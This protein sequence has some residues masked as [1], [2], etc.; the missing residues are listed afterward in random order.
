VNI[1]FIRFYEE[2]NDF[3][4]FSKQKILYSIYFR[5]NPSIKAIIE[6]E[7][8]PHTE[9]DLVLINGHSVTFQ[10]K[11]NDNDHISVY[12]KFELFDISSI[13]VIRLK[14]L[15]ETK[16]VL[17]VHLG[18]LTRYLRMLG[19]D[20]I[21]DNGFTD[22]ELLRVS[23]Q[24]NRTLLTRNRKLLMRKTVERG[25]WIR[26]DK[27]FDQVFEVFQRFDLTNTIK[28]FSI[29][30]ICNGNLHVVE[31]EIVRKQFPEFK[32]YPN[33]FFY[34]CDQCNHTYWNGSHCERFEKSMIEKILNRL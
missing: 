11:V 1:A 33:T 29:C 12:P 22:V 17:D 8:I 2:L 27:I 31:E 9:V 25:Y 32:F 19:F 26:N 3:L 14:P 28:W 21:Y 5:D 15:R 34:Q 10:E 6:S 4:P 18:K 23:M 13:N 20:S 30:T 7:G 24:E 16:F